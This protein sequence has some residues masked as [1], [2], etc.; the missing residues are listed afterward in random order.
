MQP[1]APAGWVNCPLA[2]LRR[3]TA[4]PLQNVTYTCRPSGL[5]A[6]PFAHV[7]GGSCPQTPEHGSGERA[8]V[9]GE[10]AE[11]TSVFAIGGFV[12]STSRPS[13]G[14]AIAAGLFSGAARQ[15]REP[16]DGR[17]TQ[18]ARPGSWC[19]SPVLVSRASTA[20]ALRL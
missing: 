12:Q 14:T 17:R 5:G 8:P 1:A 13:G 16:A 4:S 2:G 18:P 11:A 10:R 6:P 15:A 7:D 19:S 20:T 3:R 9:R